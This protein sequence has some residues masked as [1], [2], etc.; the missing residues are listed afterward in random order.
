MRIANTHCNMPLVDLR[1]KKAI[2]Q[3]STQLDGDVLRL[4]THP[5][6]GFMDHGLA[7]AWS[8]HG[9]KCPQA[10]GRAVVHRQ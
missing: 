6:I 8:I 5:T 9:K 4:G 10:S 1:L 3:Q 2:E 7:A